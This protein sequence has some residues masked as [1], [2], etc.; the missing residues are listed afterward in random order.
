MKT[1]LLT[2]LVLGLVAMLQAQDPLSFWP[3]QQNFTGTWYVKA[4]AANKTPPERKKPWRVSP[5][6]VTALEG[7]NW[8]AKVTFMKKGQCHEKKIVIQKTEEPGKYS[9]LQGK[10]LIYVEELPVK[11]HYAFY[12]EDQGRGKTFVM[13]KLLGRTPEENLEA[14]EEFKKFM[15]RK[16]LPQDNIVIP[17]QKDATATSLKKQQRSHPNVTEIKEGPSPLL[18]PPVSPKP[19]EL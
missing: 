18:T 15:R 9:A 6:M 2:L 4:A 13:G 17:E 14:L 5:M 1:L 7:G 16:G 12:C 11:D 19:S 10:K 3:E 8:E